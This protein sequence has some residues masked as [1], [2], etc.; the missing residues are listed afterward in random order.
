MQ[1]PFTFV[2]VLAL[3]L[4][5]G[6]CVVERPP[7]RLEGTAQDE[8]T[9]TYTL[10]EGA[11]LQI[12]NPGGAVE[13]QGVDGNAV[14]VRVERIVHAANNEAAAEIVP[15]ISI[16]EEVVP[17][18]ISIRTEGLGGIIIGVRFETTYRVRAPKT[19]RLRVRGSDSV[20]VKGFSGRVVV[21]GVNAMV[22]GEDLR[23]GVEARSV[24]GDVSITMASLGGDLVD[25]RATNGNLQ[26]TIPRNANAN[27]N[28]L[29]NRGR[30]DVTDLKYEPIGGDQ[31]Q[32]RVRGRINAG[33][34]PIEL[35]A[36]NGNIV[37]NGQ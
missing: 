22:T 26:L 10:P 33:G 31:S 23:G 1:P 16:K 18:R 7:N 21:T 2:V 14:D 30:V 6:G 4:T 20:S 3:L 24:N 36:T 11:E 8:W 15:R 17:D 37:V 27:L 32:R 12:T 29:A 25:I 5:A 9:R 34:S 19:A 13:I 28:A 35:N